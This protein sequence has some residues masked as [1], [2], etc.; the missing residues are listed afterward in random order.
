MRMDTA[1]AT[2]PASVMHLIMGQTG[3][4]GLDAA[5]DLTKATAAAS[6]PFLSGTLTFAGEAS[7]T[8]ATGT[9]G[10][11][12]T[13]KF[14]SIGTLALPAGTD[15]MLMEREPGPARAVAPWPPRAPA[16][17]VPWAP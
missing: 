13:A 16:P 15:A 17:A 11:D 14:D 4:A 2:A 9:A 5:G 6:G 7:G 1:S 10:G 3:A 8:M 12:F